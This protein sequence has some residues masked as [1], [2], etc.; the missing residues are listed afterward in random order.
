[1]L[2]SYLVPCEQEEMIL[3]TNGPSDE[4]LEAIYERLDELDPSTFEVR[5]SRGS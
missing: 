1:M 5:G 2:G 4:R 3:E